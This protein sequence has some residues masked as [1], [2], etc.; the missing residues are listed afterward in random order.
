MESKDEVIVKRDKLAQ[1]LGRG[2]RSYFMSQFVPGAKESD[3]TYECTTEG[4]ESTVRFR[5]D[6]VN[7]KL[8]KS[9]RLEL[10]LEHPL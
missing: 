10:H 5:I 6:G 2:L 4:H 8:F 9:V 3:V 1:A 7:S